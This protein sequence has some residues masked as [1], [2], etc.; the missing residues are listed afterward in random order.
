MSERAFREVPY[1]M[2]ALAARG[3]TLALSGWC[4]ECGRY[5]ERRSVNEPII[6]PRTGETHRH[7]RPF[8][9]GPRPEA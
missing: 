8:E 4:S 6:D 3:I 7:S 1:P 9:I 2:P 5:F